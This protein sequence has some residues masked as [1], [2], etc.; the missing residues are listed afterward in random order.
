MPHFT[1][2][3]A[4]TLKDELFLKIDAGIFTLFISNK[5]S[6]DADKTNV[7]GWIKTP[8][9]G[10]LKNVCLMVKIRTDRHR[11]FVFQNGKWQKTNAIYN[12]H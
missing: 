1:V 9:I 10:H 3:Y 6:P 5:K 7:L 4:I 11:T 2:G 12:K 8:N